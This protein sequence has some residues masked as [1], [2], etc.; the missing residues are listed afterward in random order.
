LEPWGKGIARRKLRLSHFR[1]ADFGFFR[2]LFSIRIP[3]STIRN[4]DG[5]SVPWNQK[6]FMISARDAFAPGPGNRGPFRIRLE[7]FPF[8]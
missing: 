7:R 6:R 2:V 8:F 1:I 5:P 3:Q 4:P